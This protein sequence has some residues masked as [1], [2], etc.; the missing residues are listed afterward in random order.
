[1]IE[2]SKM[3]YML[4]DISSKDMSWMSAFVILNT[5]KDEHFNKLFDS[6]DVTSMNQFLSGTYSRFV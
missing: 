3:G 6:F 4:H 1:M 2:S 5:K